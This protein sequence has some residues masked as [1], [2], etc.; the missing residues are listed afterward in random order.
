MVAKVVCGCGCFDQLAEI[1]APKRVNAETPFIFLVDHFFANHALLS[2]IPITGPDKI[3][4][5]DVSHE[6]KTTQVDKL[7]D[8]LQ[9]GF[10]A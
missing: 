8:E 4:L 6:P 7:R 5:A 1:I 3:I 9:A 10:R 2:R